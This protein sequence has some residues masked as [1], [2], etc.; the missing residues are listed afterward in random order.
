M[1][2]KYCTATE[3]NPR[4]PLHVDRYLMRGRGL[5]GDRWK[6]NITAIH[7]TRG[8]NK[9]YFIGTRSKDYLSDGKTMARNNGFTM[10]KFI[11][12]CPMC[13]RVLTN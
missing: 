4:K 9:K 10:K 13:A 8:R 12:Y 7:R 11:N 6:R 5:A 1:S 2:C 3:H